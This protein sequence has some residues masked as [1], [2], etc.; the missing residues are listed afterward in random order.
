MAPAKTRNAQGRGKRQISWRNSTQ[1]SNRMDDVL[2][3][4]H[5]T[6]GA[7]VR[8]FSDAQLRVRIVYLHNT[9]VEK[10]MHEQDE[11]ELEDIAFLPNMSFVV[12]WRPSAGNAKPVEEKQSTEGAA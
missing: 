8:V 7:H 2:Y 12:R 5:P 11:L 3:F 6:I 1:A 9:K 10:E 4:T